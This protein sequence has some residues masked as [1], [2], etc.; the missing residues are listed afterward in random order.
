MAIGAIVVSAVFLGNV[1]IFKRSVRYYAVFKDVQA[2]PNKAAVKIAGVEIGKVARIDLID[3]K[4]RVAMDI[5]PK[6]P[7]YID[8]AASIGST[9]IIGTKFVEVKT[10]TDG[11]NQRLGDGDTMRT[12][13]GKGLNEMLDR[14][15]SLFDDDGKNGNAVDNLKAT[16]ANIRR[17][18]DALN[19]AMGNHAVEMEEI[20]MNVRD[21]SQSAKVFMKHMEEISTEKKEDVKVAITKIRDAADKLDA[22]LGKVQRGEGVAGALVSDDKAGND[23]REAV[24]SIKDTANSAK[25]VLGRF[26]TIHTYWNY[27]YRYDFRDG[28]GKSDLSL[29]FVPRPGKFY[30]IGV[31]NLGDPPEDEK[32][33][34]FE[35]KNRFTATLGQDFGPLTGYVGVIKSRSGFGVTLRPLTW[36]PKLYHRFELNAEASDFKR[37]DVV[38][39]L[40][41]T[42]PLMSAG[43]HVAVTNWL[44]IGARAEDVLERSAFMA[45]TNIVFRD[46]DLPYF[47]GFATL[48]R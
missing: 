10:G 36:L 4:A 34:Q 28:E 14:L 9:G 23:V 13:E 12:V 33:T 45:Y 1:R 7:L 8:A 26:T 46:D 43:A 22:I 38:N 29:K 27:R 25:K 11:N 47:F 19:V 37:D 6:I 21:L 31:T 3:G 40:H 32:H 15:S 24:A 48:S 44:W 41:R 30:A 2:L 5:D 42:K 20:V 39:G 35:R 16:L 18:S 17:V